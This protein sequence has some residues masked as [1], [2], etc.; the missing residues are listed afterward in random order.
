MCLSG[1]R[2]WGRGGVVYVS[3]HCVMCATNWSK[4]YFW[5]MF[6]RTRVRSNWFCTN[7]DFVVEESSK[8]TLAPRLTEALSGGI[9]TVVV[10]VNVMFSMPDT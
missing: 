3:E 10:V 7:D 5:P 2:V 4:Q 6:I 1:V 9:N 8:S